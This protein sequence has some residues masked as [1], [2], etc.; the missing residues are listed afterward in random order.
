[1]SDHHRYEELAVGHVLGGLDDVDQAEFRTHLLT[2]RDCRVRVAE[3]RD[4]ASSMEAA[5]REERTAARVKMEVLRR[6]DGAETGEEQRGGI[7]TVRGAVVALVATVALVGLLVWNFHVRDVNRAL[8]SATEAREATLTLL[9][10]GQPLTVEA[11]MD[12][13]AGVAAYDAGEVAVDL[14]GLPSPEGGEWFAV[15]LLDAADQPI[16]YRHYPATV[17]DD[18]V[19]AAV[20]GARGAHTLLFTL[21][22]GDVTGRTAP[23]GARLA[24][25]DLGR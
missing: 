2:C 8:L 9:A 16:Q 10:S 24:A 20:V 11:T 4:I 1:M 5:E 22:Q 23:E 7:R 14:A 13:V 21:E 25:V 6:E 19:F 17:V 12:G 18:G 3:L 15:W